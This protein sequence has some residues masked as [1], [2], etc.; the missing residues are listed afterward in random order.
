MTNTNRIYLDNAATTP[1]H[2]EV[3]DA[4]L[5]WMGLATDGRFGN[6]SALNSEGRLARQALEAARTTLAAA[7]GATPPEIVFTSGGTES[8]NALIAGLT[9]GVRNKSG[10]TKGGNLVV[11]SAFEH[12]AVLEPVKTL[13]RSGWVIELVKPTRSGFVEPEQLFT[14]IENAAAANNTSCTL[15]SVMTANN[16]VGT[17]QPI[18]ELAR[19]AQ[20]LGALMHTD[21]CQALGKTEFH[22]A[23]LGVDAASFSAHKIGGPKGI[24][25]FYLKSLTPFRPQQLGGGQEREMRSGTVNVAGAIGFAK[26]VELALADL[27]RETARMAKLRDHLAGELLA[28]SSRVHLTVDPRDNGAVMEGTGA[29]SGSYLPNAT[30]GGVSA[31]GTTGAGFLPNIV[32]VLVDGFES[33]SLILAL[34][35]RGFAVSGGSACTS[36]SLEPSHVLLAMGIRRAQAQS[37]LRISLGRETTVHGIAAFVEAFVDVVGSDGRLTR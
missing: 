15:V 20:S 6:S 32:S 3:L 18:A 13:K 5:P 22:V 26:A 2:P 23:R 28:A 8:N 4:M 11:T 31:S 14:A 16:E 35:E 24:G 10:Q 7:V 34:D 19:I 37:V 30:I 17:V 27:E 33:E 9:E 25:A 36:D 12:H 1:L 21:A 29:G